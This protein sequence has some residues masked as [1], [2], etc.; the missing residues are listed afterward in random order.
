MRG[1]V[2]KAVGIAVTTILLS[3]PPASAIDFRKEIK[4][5]KVV[6]NNRAN[7]QTIHYY[8]HSRVGSKYSVK[9]TREDI[10][11]LHDLTYFDDIALEVEEKADGL[12]LIYR[13]KEKPFVRSVELKG[14]S[15]VPEKDMRLLIQ[16]KKG[17]YFQKHLL[18]KDIAKI[19][20][21]Y[22]KKGFYF[23][24]VDAEIKEAGDDQ[25][26]ITYN[27]EE[28]QKVKISEI[29]FREN[30]Q[31]KE[32]LL[33]ETIESKEVDFFSFFNDSGNFEKEILKTDVLRLE[34]RYRDEGFINATIESPRIEIDRQKGTIYITMVVHEGE[35]YFFGKI[36]AEGDNLYSAEEILKN[37]SVKEG[38][39]FNQTSFR[40]NLFKITEM[41]SNKGYAYANPIPSMKENEEEKVIDIHIKVDAGEK[42]YIGRIDIKGNDKTHENVIRREFRLHEGELFNGEKMQRTRQRLGNTGYFEAVE[43]EQKSGSQPNLMDLEVTVVEKPTGNLQAGIGYSFDEEVSVTAKVSENNLF[44]TGKKLSLSIDQ[45]K[46]RRDYYMDFSQP[47]FLDRD[48]QLGYQVYS[49]QFDYGTSTHGYTRFNKGAS[50]SLGRGLNEYAYASFLYRLESSEVMPTDGSALSPILQSQQGVKVTSSIQP[51]FVHDTRDNYYVTTKGHRIRAN[52]II[53]GGPLNGDLDFYKLGF[54]AWQYIPLPKEFVIFGRGQINYG[55]GYNGDKLPLVENFYLGGVQSLR[56]FSYGDVGPK[57]ANGLPLG[58][59]SSLLFNLEVHYHF[60]KTVKGILFYDR[61]QVYGEGEDLS[62]TTSR[63]FDIENM[64]QGVGF[65]MNFMTPMMP[66][67]LAWGFKLDKMPGETS[68]QFHFNIG[69]VGF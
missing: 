56:G 51:I 67:T 63:R 10:R 50:V 19:K 31:L 54:E 36:T 2:F 12:V 22:Q 42:I 53:A 33:K 52:T 21:K 46:L 47:K 23:T 44:G 37:I 11:R 5:I 26:D 49:R 65:G 39:P 69:G 43:I 61:G 41:Y 17:T 24:T 55:S 29:R 62:T 14:A 60:S 38:E 13:L 66:I 28:K 18:K 32:Y 64:R 8:I 59:D 40:Q 58:G 27:I 1:S 48:I 68:M 7:I 16:M 25:V 35:Q 6:G 15:E 20:E 34:S 3:V 4:D 57:D 30:K 9:T 45:S